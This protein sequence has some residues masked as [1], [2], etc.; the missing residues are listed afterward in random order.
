MK[1]VDLMQNGALRS[2]LRKRRGTALT[3]YGIFAL[4]QAVL[5]VWLM[6]DFGS[7]TQFYCFLV[8]IAAIV[9]LCRIVRHLSLS[10][11]F[12]PLREGE[13]VSETIQQTTVPEIP[14]AKCKGK[15]VE[16]MT[17]K[18]AINASGHIYLLELKEA[19]Q[20][21]L[22]AAGDRVLFSNALAA[23]ILTSRIPTKYAC[24][25]CGAI[26]PLT[27]ETTAC[28]CGSPVLSAEKEESVG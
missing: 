17:A 5:A 19:D 12:S 21:G 11:A 9:W 23:P 15:Q 24:P 18:L 22:F 13:V 8:E 27:Q 10:C 6:T 14:F 4:M 26:F 25:F 1:Q 16:L 2:F 20:S 28:R 7:K 3:V